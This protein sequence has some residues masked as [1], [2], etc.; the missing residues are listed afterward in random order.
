MRI[1]EIDSERR[2]LS[3]SAKRVE[4]QILPLSRPP[5]SDAEPTGD[6]QEQPAA[7]AAQTADP[8]PDGEGH[9]DGAQAQGQ[10]AGETQ[11]ATQPDASGAEGEAA[12]AAQPEQA[13]Q[14]EDRVAPAEPAEP[15]A[16]GEPV[17]DAQ[18]VESPQD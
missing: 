13:E 12:Q 2:R 7:A 17:P 10:G 11:A 14:A 9:G 15:Q 1:L 18:P 16:S 4:D 8:A 3:L 5:R 6:T